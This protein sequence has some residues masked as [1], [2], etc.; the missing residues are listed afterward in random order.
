MYTIAAKFSQQSIAHDSL[1]SFPI[2]YATIDSFLIIR[3]LSQ[4]KEIFT[5][6]LDFAVRNVREACC[7]PP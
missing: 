3:R 7:D 6:G 2:V 4:S 1:K 5:S